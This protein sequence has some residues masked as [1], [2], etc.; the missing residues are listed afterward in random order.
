MSKAAELRELI[1]VEVDLYGLT[2]DDIAYLIESAKASGILTAN[3][4]N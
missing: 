1:R 4:K 3:R 2:A